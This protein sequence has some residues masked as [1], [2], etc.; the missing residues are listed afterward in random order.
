LLNP[1][2]RDM[3][4]EFSAA[5][6]EF[7]LVGAYAMAVHGVPRAT[8]DLDLWV[9]C[10]D[11]NAPRVLAALARF[12]AP[13]AGLSAADFAT[14]GVVFQIGLAPRRVD[15][16]T[17]IDGVAFEEAWRDRVEVEVEGQRIPVISRA[18]LLQNK[19]AS[20][21]PKDMVDVRWLEDEGA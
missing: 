12:G 3:L 11:E 4:S 10:S 17:A 14:P 9:R 21:R 1:D 20:G 16:L 6:V 19:R 5:G 8:G 15:I 18:H 7:L 2:F 13:V